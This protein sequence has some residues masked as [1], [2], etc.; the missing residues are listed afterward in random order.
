[1]NTKVTTAE[2][3]GSGIKVQECVYASLSH[4]VNTGKDRDS[5]GRQGGRD[6]V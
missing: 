2:K 4:D 3:T 5:E 6:G 1:M